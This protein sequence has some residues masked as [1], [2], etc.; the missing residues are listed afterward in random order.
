MKKILIIVCV[1]VGCKGFSQDINQSMKKLNKAVKQAEQNKK[2]SLKLLQQRPIRTTEDPDAA[3]VQDNT[4]PNNQVADSTILLKNTVAQAD[5]LKTISQ[6]EMPKE[7]ND[8]TG[9]WV[10]LMVVMLLLAGLVIGLKRRNALHKRNVG[11]PR[12]DSE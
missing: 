11:R 6:E 9:L 8:K 10:F 2:D 12:K 7:N 5:S 1:L 3:P 4:T